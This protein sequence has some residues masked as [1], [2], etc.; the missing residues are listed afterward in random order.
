MTDE[1][2]NNPY[3]APDS[4][5]Q[6]PATP[7]SPALASRLYR[8][9]GSII[10]CLVQ[11]VVIGPIIYFSGI[12]DAMMQGTGDISLATS[13]GLFIAG[14]LIFLA[15]QG[16]LL[17][18]RQQTIGKAILNMRIVGMEQDNVPAGKL[19]GLR[20]FVF[21]V[22]AQ[23]PGVNLIM[24]VDPLLIFRSDR[25]CLH[26]HLAGTQVIQTQSTTA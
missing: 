26:D 21:H 11:L 1:S 6:K 17:F 5:S 8:F 23:L 20:Y 19:Y 7:G 25:R 9:L 10:D 16:W 15:L 13:A 2:P 22:L 3:Q 18:N 4:T 14:E 24:I 12:W